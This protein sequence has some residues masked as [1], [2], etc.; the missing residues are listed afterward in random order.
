MVFCYGVVWVIVGWDG[1]VW[2]LDDGWE[3]ESVFKNRN[4]VRLK[5]GGGG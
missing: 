4:S 2:V 3:I 1:V 5:R